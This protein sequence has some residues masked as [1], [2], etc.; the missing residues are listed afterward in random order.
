MFAKLFGRSSTPKSP[1][2]WKQL[3]N[4]GKIAEGKNALQEPKSFYAEAIEEINKVAEDEGR[5]ARYFAFKI[6]QIRFSLERVESQL[7]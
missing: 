2:I 5:H 7:S 1:K 6:S 4:K 3:E